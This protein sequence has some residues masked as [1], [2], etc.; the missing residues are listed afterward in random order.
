M[1]EHHRL[2]VALA[3]V[4]LAVPARA[5]DDDLS[6]REEAA[7]RAAMSRVTPSVVSIETVGGLERVGQ[8]LFGTGPTTGLV[9]TS[10]GYIISSAFNFAQKPASILVELADG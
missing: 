4:L 6:S 10:D 5:S 3:W 9:V 7:M 1:S 2:L 8:V